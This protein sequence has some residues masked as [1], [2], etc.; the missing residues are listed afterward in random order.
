M[1]SG[2]RVWDSLHPD[3]RPMFSMMWRTYRRLLSRIEADPGAAIQRRVCRS[4]R[5]QIELAS[6]HFIAPIFRR[7][8]VP[9]QEVFG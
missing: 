7:L 5:D 3:G 1:D 9:P 6:Q 2:W 4:R 8:P